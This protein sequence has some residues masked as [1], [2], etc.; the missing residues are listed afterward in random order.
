MRGRRKQL[1][2]SQRSLVERLDSLSYPMKQPVIARIEVGLRAVS[3]NDAVA[4]AAALNTTAERL[5]APEPSWEDQLVKRA[6]ES[7]EESELVWRDEQLRRQEGATRKEGHEQ[8][9]D[10]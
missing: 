2:M 3:L 9:Q 7:H 10:A 8:P 4:I 1:G 5:Y 6:E